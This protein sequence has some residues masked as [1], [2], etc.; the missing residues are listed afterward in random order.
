MAIL[1]ETTGKSRNLIDFGPD[2]PLPPAGTYMATVI[3]IEDRF[4]VERPTF[5]DPTV[6][7]VVDLTQFAFGFRDRDGNPFKVAS[8]VM[9]ISGHEKSALFGF[10][11]ALTGAAPKMGWD[12]CATKGTKCLLTVEHVAGRSGSTYPQ[13]AALSPVP[14]GY[15]QAPAPA[16]AP[17]APPARP[18]P[19]RPVPQPAAPPPE[20][21][22]V[23]DVSDPIPF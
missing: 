13:I 10:L 1:T 19:R 11:K 21:A 23:A 2:N 8:K 14:E 20:P 7:E 16:P 3:A 6:T 22:P 5:D 12:Y 18:E 17:A 9:R 4:K 15:G